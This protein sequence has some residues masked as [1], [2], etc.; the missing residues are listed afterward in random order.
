MRVLFGTMMLTA[1]AFS[2]P[3]MAAI[4]SEAT[5]RL[6]ASLDL[7]PSWAVDKGNF[8]SENELGAAYSITEDFSLGYVQ[9]FRTNLY[10]SEQDRGLDLQAWDGYAKAEVKDLYA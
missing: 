10:N 2:P 4:E 7:R 3:T 9:E 8:H 5:S 6:E 1:L